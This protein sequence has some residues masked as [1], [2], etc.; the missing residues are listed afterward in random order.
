M[1]TDQSSPSSTRLGCGGGCNPQH[2]E[3]GVGDD[4][5]DHVEDETHGE[6]GHQAPHPLLGL[7]LGLHD[8]P[9]LEDV[10]VHDQGDIT[11][12]GEASGLD[13]GSEQKTWRGCGEL[14]V[15]IEIGAF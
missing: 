13:R 8:A 12:L 1:C 6:A 9:D 11:V 3:N 2:I 15:S 10:S 14:E 5:L 7:A 4:V